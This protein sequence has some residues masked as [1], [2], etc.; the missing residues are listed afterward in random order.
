VRASAAVVWAI[1]GG[2]LAWDGAGAEQLLYKLEVAATAGHRLGGHIG[3]SEMTWPG[4]RRLPTHAEARCRA[5]DS[6][7]SPRSASLRDD[8]ANTGSPWHLPA[9]AC[10]VA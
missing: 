6:Q 7:R 10:H 3:T 9:P 5:L 4:A 8:E 2:T 1:Y